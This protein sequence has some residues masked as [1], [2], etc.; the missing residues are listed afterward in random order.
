[1]S[2]SKNLRYLQINPRDPEGSL[3]LIRDLIREMNGRL[4][5][6]DVNGDGLVIPAGAITQAELADDSVGSAQIIADAVGTGEIA[7]RAVTKA[8][9]AGGFLACKT[10]AGGAAGAHT[11]TGIA[12]GDEIVAVLRFNRDATASN[13]DLSTLTSEF[14]ITGT[15][16]ISNAG[17][18][19]TTGDT[20]V[21]LWLDLT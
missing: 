2:E 18:T 13:I 10:I 12:T 8:E 3:L 4:D 16:S 21:V 9:L 7:P 5:A 17:G 6:L 19:A 14:T 15:D 20:L 1:M 11:V